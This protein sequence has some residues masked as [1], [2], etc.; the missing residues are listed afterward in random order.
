MILYGNAWFRTV[1]M[2]GGGRLTIEI[3]CLTLSIPQAHGVAVSGPFEFSFFFLLDF[4]YRIC[5]TP[6]C[7]SMFYKCF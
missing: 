1:A 5:L 3:V 2:Q 4:C 6:V 7:S